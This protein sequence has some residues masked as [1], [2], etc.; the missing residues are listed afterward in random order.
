MNQKTVSDQWSNAAGG[1]ARWA[2]VRAALVPATEAM[3]A[4]AAVASGSRVLDVGCGSGEQTVIAAHRVGETGHVLAIDIAAPMIAATQKTVAAAGLHNVSTRVC[5]ADAL[6]DGGEKFDAAISR[7]VLMLIPDPI[8]AARA[9]RAVLLPGGPFAAMVHGDP[10]KNPLNAMAMEILARHGGKTVRA[11]GPGFFALADP[12]R[13]EA[14]LRSAGFADVAVTSMSFVRRLDNA[15][16]AV[17]MIRDAFAVCQVLVADLPPTAQDAA[18]TEVEQALARFD[19][20][21]G[22]VCPGEVNLVV[23]RKPANR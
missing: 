14:V 15:A 8:A 3:L 21:N 9:V 2:S 17:V 4:L 22:F 5:A 11:D 10:G 7:F 23:G 16:A 19:G 1:W 13:L 6:A 12:A 20:P 18:W